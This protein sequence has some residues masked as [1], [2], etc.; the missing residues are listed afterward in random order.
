MVVELVRQIKLTEEKAI[1]SLKETKLKAKRII[2]DAHVESDNIMKRTENESKDERKKLL[3]KAI[4]KGHDEVVSL[5]KG[6]EIKR[7]QLNE[8]SSKNHEKAKK[9]I[10]D[11][12]LTI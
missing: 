11:E 6:N 5:K 3:S 4:N 1:D 8:S 9:F 7:N 2:E 12:L 10:L